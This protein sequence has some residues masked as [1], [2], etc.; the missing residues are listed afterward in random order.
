[1]SGLRLGLKKLL[2]RLGASSDG[3]TQGERKTLQLQ[4]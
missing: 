3:Q 2:F 4:M 1:M